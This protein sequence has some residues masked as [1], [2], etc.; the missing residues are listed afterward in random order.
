VEEQRVWVIVALTSPR[1]DWER[2]GEAYRV[3]ARFEVRA[4]DDALRVPASAVFRHG[5][6]DAVFRMVGGRAALAP[7]TIGVQGG[8]FV[9]IRAGLAAGDTV[10]VHPDRALADGDRVRLR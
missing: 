6:G 3:N 8:G 2:L 7:V 9:Q 1:A 4:V 10:I 5:S